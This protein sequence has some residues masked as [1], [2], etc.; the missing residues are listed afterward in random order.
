MVAFVFAMIGIGKE[1]KQDKLNDIKKYTECRERTSDVEWC[2]NEFR[3]FL[4][5][6]V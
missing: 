4:N 5:R 3:P 6:E 1:A 2:F